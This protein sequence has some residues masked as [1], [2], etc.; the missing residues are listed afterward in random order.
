MATNDIAGV[1]SAAFRQLSD[2]LHQASVACK[3]LEYTVPIL[4]R[5]AGSSASPIAPATAAADAAADK[6]K[7]KRDPNEPRRPPSGYLL[8]TADVREGVQKANA[9]MKPADVMSKLAS[10]WK[11]LTD[12]QKRVHKH[13]SRNR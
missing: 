11:D 5:A 1:L 7:R 2:A 12:A 3:D 10:M 6:K 8:F 9:D 4:A 13:S